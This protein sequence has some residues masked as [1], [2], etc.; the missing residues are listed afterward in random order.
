MKQDQKQVEETPLVLVSALPGVME[1]FSQGF[2]KG[3]G[4]YYR[5]AANDISIKPKLTSAHTAIA[6]TTAVRVWGSRADR[7]L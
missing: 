4:K 2:V 1:A 7:A 5:F 3:A 6:S